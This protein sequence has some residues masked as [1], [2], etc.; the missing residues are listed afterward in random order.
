MLIPANLVCPVVV[1]DEADEVAE[2]LLVVATVAED[3]T[4]E[5]EATGVVTLTAVAVVAGA[6]A[7]VVAD[8]TT[9]AIDDVLEV[10]G[11]DTEVTRV[12][13]DDVALATA[14]E[15]TSAGLQVSSDT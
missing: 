2:P 12:D 1:D 6:V 15:T 10:A 7:D 9:T 4:E 13:N 5:D 11:S 3:T 8:V 14:E